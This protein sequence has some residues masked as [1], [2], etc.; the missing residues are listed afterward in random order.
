M[1]QFK[2]K[3]NALRS[4]KYG[5]CSQFRYKVQIE[6]YF[7]TLWMAVVS[8]SANKCNVLLWKMERNSTG[9]YTNRR[10]RC[11]YFRLVADTSFFKR[12]G[13]SRPL[14]VC[15][16]GF[17]GDLTACSR[18]NQERVGSVG[19]TMC[20][21]HFARRMRKARAPEGSTGL[22]WI[23]RLVHRFIL[24]DI[25]TMTETTTTPKKNWA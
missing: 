15:S 22:E 12:G 24:R 20:W 21:L 14:L 1:I 5:T 7:D 23:P 13:I 2:R 17:T 19:A 25:S 6:R 18:Y 16:F 4:K 9:Q 3:K 11:Q 8:L 10:G